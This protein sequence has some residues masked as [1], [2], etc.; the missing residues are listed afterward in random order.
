MIKKHP[1]NPQRARRIA[2]SFVEVLHE[3]EKDHLLPMPETI[4]S[5]LQ[6]LT[7]KVDK[8]ATVIIDKNRYS[9]ICKP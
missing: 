2:G 7:G 4:F 9:V 1:I 5:N 3:T 8:Y 6:T